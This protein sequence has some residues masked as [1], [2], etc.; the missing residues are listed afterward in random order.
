[1]ARGSG[2]GGVEG[3]FLGVGFVVIVFSESINWKDWWDSVLG[4][5]SWDE[6]FDMFKKIWNYGWFDD[7]CIPWCKLFVMLE[8]LNYLFIIYNL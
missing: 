2:G 4:F 5:C 1:M 3:G 7:L 8:I 6:G